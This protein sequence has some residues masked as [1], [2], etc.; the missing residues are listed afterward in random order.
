MTAFKSSLLAIEIEEGKGAAVVIG[1][2]KS[3]A[4]QQVISSQNLNITCNQE[5]SNSNSQLVEL[6]KSR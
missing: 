4:N 3:R 5:K 6:T 1:I 2:D